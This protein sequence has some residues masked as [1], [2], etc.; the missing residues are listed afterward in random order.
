MSVTLASQC[1]SNLCPIPVLYSKIPEITPKSLIFTPKSPFL[2][3]ISILLDSTVLVTS[4]GGTSEYVSGMQTMTAR[5]QCA[6]E[7][8]GRGHV[9]GIFLRECAHKIILARNLL[10]QAK[11]RSQIPVL[12]FALQGTGKVGSADHVGLQP[13]DCNCDPAVDPSTYV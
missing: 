13:R 7:G 4:V 9:D 3:L 10:R 2:T 12:I 5:V 6:D 11:D 8:G 1:M